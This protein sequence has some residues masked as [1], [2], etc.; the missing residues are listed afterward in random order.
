MRSAST[1]LDMRSLSLYLDE[2]GLLL[3]PGS[4]AS[5]TF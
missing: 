1:G 5:F 3:S 4:F 2:L